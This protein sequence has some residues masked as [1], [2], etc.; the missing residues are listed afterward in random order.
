MDPVYALAVSLSLAALFGGAAVHQCRG[1]REWQGVVA[2]YRILPQPVVPVAAL[3]LPC[4]EALVALALAAGAARA[5]AATAAA[6]LLLL[7]A[8]AIGINVGRGRTRIDCGCFGS[9]LGHGIGS[10]MVVR[11]ALL[12][13][14]ALTLL[15]P[16]GRRVLSVPEIAFVVVLVVTAGFLYPVLAVV[17]APRPPLAAGPPQQSRPTAAA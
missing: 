5:F 15:L 7:Y 2:N 16:V 11:N 9:R 10:W 17:T 6:G 3:A 4:A 8:L 12:A 1:W 14:L 13:C